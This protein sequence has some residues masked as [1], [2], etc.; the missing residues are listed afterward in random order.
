MHENEK[1]EVISMTKSVFEMQLGIMKNTLKLMEFKF[2]G[3]DSEPFKYVKEQLMNFHYEGL[4]KFYQQGVSE[5]VFEKCECGAS[6]RHGWQTCNYCSGSGF[7]DKV[8]N[9]TKVGISV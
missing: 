1:K 4:K 6:L 2:G 8:K 9:E 7:R 5:G 3:R